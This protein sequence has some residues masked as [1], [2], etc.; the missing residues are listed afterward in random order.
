MADLPTQFRVDWLMDGN[1]ASTSGGVHHDGELR[2][3]IGMALAAIAPEDP[4]ALPGLLRQLDSL[5][6]EPRIEA[7]R[8]IGSRGAAAA[9]AV[10]RIAALLAT[11][12]GTIAYEAATTLGMLGAA[13]GP[14]I[15]QLEQA[16]T[17]AD[18]Q[19]AA[20]AQAALRRVRG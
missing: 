15:P 1:Q 11:E 9:D 10:S 7:L 6:A 14:A 18:K 17:S 16:S 2:A 20:R 12:S 19:L 5:A 8:A 3:A 4:L 13:A